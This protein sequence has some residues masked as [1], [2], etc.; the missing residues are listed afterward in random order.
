MEVKLLKRKSW[1]DEGGVSEIVGNILILMITVVLF[2]G[3]MMFVNQM[4]VPELTTKADFAASLDFDDLGSTATLT[5]THIGGAT[6][7]AP[8]TIILVSVDEETWAYRL[9]EDAD[10]D[11]D[12]WAM[13]TQWVK[14]FSD[15]T[16]S[17]SISVT[18]V[19]DESHNA[20]WTSQVSGGM[21]GTPPIVLQRYV[22]SNT[23]T[24]TVDPVK[25]YDDFTLYVKI[26]DLDKDL[27]YV[28]LDSSSI[29]GGSANDTFNSPSSGL[30]PADGGW[31]E[32]DF[33]DVANDSVA[34]DGKTLKIHAMDAA[35]HTTSVGYELSVIVL[36]TD[37]D[38]Y[39]ADTTPQEGG[40]PSYITNINDGQGFGVYG[41]NGTSGTANT[42]DARTNFTRGENI[43][44]RVASL[45]VTNIGGAN[46]LTMTDART[47][48]DYTSLAVFQSPSTY[49]DPFYS[50]AYGGNV[51]VYQAV[52]NTTNMIPGTYTMSM[53]LKATGLTNY[54]FDADQT[55]YIEDESSPISYYP[56]VWT[57]MDD[58]YGTEWGFD[59]DTAFNATGTD[60]VIYVAIYVQ[61]AQD[62]PAPSVGEIRIVDMVGGTQL[63]GPPDS[64]SMISEVTDSATNNTAY[65]FSID[66]RFSNGDQWK[67][68][69]NSYT[70]QISQFSDAN[71]GVYAY[72]RQVFVQA[73]Y[74]RADFFLGT[75]G[76]YSSKGGSTNFINPEYIYYV[77]NNNFFTTRI[78]YTQEN[79]PSTAPLY[80][81]NAMSVGDYDNDGDMDVLA[82]SNMDKATSYDDIG[83][84]LYF[85]NT[86]NTYGV[87]QAPSIITRPTGDLATDK[88]EWID[89]GD[90]NGDGDTDFA[91][92]TSGHKVIIF[93]N[94]YGA[95]GTVFATYNS[96]NDGI[97]KIALEDM[98]GDGCADLIVLASG[99]VWMY[100]LTKWTRGCFAYLPNPTSITSNI[101]DFDIADINNDG[102]LDII[103]VDP[104]T[105]TG[106]HDYIEGVWVN[107]YTVNQDAEENLVTD[108]LQYAGSNTA[109]IMSLTEIADDNGMRIEEN[110]T[111]DEAGQVHFVFEID[112]PLTS[113]SDPQ[114]VVTAKVGPEDT[115]QEVFYVWYTT[116]SD[117]LTA[118]YTPVMVITAEEYTEYTFSLPSSV[119]GAT[120]FYVKITDSST[121]LGLETEWL[122]I[123]Y[124]GVQSDRFGSYMPTTLPVPANR[125]QVAG[126]NTSYEIYY[127]ARA[128]NFDGLE[129]GRLEVVVA[130]NAKFVVYDH[131]T[132]LTAWMV[133]NQTNMYIYPGGLPTT[134]AIGPTLLEVEDV[135][136]DGLDDILTSWVTAGA[137]SEVSLLKV[138]L[139]VGPTEYWAVSIKDVFAGMLTGTETGCIVKIAAI[140]IYGRG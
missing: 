59:R 49:V 60:Y 45:Y 23:D 74:S 63:Y 37:I 98:T 50:Y 27:R 53:L 3:I 79:A 130:K 9:S 127:T 140:D 131:R 65:V 43:F 33:N 93:N 83:K 17:S 15:T 107:N 90:I 41:E 94:T 10:F 55:I 73:S 57:F 24:P 102:M 5:V 14:T 4:P 36:P 86:M 68:G 112:V 114:L 71:E 48:I 6:M 69:T 47:E 138:Y 116:S 61:D 99:K 124:I 25:E 113:Y 91:Y 19:D 11:Y 136:G 78:L 89:S 20:V 29:T 104:T 109:G 39:P 110:T 51:A 139:N 54:V 56:R 40:M 121:A 132:P 105:G 129:D 62:S 103:T 52:F 58:D 72:S 70:L 64:G 35:G 66:L 96:T 8:L 101:E 84:L 97:R 85:E 31:F 95:Q 18:I 44:V 81:H 118:I 106:T 133:Q 26:S 28:W 7:E 111:G 42:T 119:A 92:S 2:S 46:D 13:G 115:S 108:V 137:A 67:S 38:W 123:D 88:I 75:S 87:W 80:Y 122:D 100:D 21:G 82:G 125:Y 134:V 1:T 128:I 16:Y 34:I 30:V 126:V 22:D 117:P 135:N 120:S 12:E 77:E 32:W 76:V